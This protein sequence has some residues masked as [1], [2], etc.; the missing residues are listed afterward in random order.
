MNK[1]NEKIKNPIFNKK[2]LKAAIE[3]NVCAAIEEDLKN[4]DKT[5]NILQKKI[6]LL[7]MFILKIKLNKIILN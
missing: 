7:F 2:L 5:S 1:I 3:K 6:K 4:I